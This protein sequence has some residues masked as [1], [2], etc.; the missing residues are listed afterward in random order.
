[1]LALAA[2]PVPTAQQD[3]VQVEHRRGQRDEVEHARERDHAVAEVVELGRDRQVLR[4]AA[5][6]VGPSGEPMQPEEDRHRAEQAPR[7]NAT[8]TFDDRSDATMPTAISIA[9]IS[10]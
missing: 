7:M 3:H 6:A 2:R 8:V 9:P 5:G 4:S 10:Q 1:M